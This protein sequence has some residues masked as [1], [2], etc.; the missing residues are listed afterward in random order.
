MRKMWGLFLIVVLL[1]SFVMAGCSDDDPTEP[2]DDDPVVLPP[3]PD[4]LMT[5]FV[6]AYNDMDQEL[7]STLIH[8]DFKGLLSSST[9]DEWEYSGSPLT[10]TYFERDTVL[11][12]HDHI[13]SG[14]IGRRPYGAPVPPVDS[15]EVAV[16]DKINAWGNI[17][18]GDEDFGGH[19]GSWT[20]YNVVIHFNLPD[21]SRYRVQEIM[22][23]YVVPVE[24]DG[25]VGYQLL[26]WREIE[27]FVAGKATE[28]LNLGD[29][30]TLYR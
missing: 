15:I 2:V 30:L 4:A 28:S 7:F 26:G 18:P 19:A 11:A 9:L 23:F 16:I 24:N 27:Q 8:P 1:G 21:Q 29:I 10:F 20:L 25:V 14:E 6:M 12:I 22:A 5:G 13:F 3:D 17:P